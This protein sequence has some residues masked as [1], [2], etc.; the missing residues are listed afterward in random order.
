[1]IGTLGSMPKGQHQA[2]AGDALRQDVLQWLGEYFDEHG[3][4][5]TTTEV[6][7]HFA[8]TPDSM[9]THLHWLEDHGHVRFDT[10]TADRR[11]QRVMVRL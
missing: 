6:A 10:D 5:P 7:Q 4:G 1:M 3:F 9:R 2:A 11:L 8:R